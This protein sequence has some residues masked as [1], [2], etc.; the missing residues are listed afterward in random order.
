MYLFTC[1]INFI[2]GYLYKVISHEIRNWVM[3]IASIL[4]QKKP[5]TVNFIMH[6]LII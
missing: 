3:V 5:Q 6:I 4:L 1:Y 2:V